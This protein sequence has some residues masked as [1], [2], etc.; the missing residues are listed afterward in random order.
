M[1]F[2]PALAVFDLDGTLADTRHDIARALLHVIEQQG[3][4]TPSLATA[5][6][7]IGW[8]APALVRKA[9]GPEHEHRA[10]AILPLFR[11]RYREHLV[12]ETTVYPGIE[13]LLADLRSGGTRLA[14]ATNKPSELTVALL[15]RLE[16]A[17]L[18]D[19]AVAPE[20]VARPKPAPDML[21]LLLQRTGVTADDAVM[22]GDM[23]T[24]VDS[25]HAA[26]MAAVLCRFSGFHRDADL[27]ERAEHVADTVH[28]LHTL[29]VDG[30]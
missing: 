9:L 16:L 4:P 3:L 11:R 27:G 17:P 10:N 13:R 29:L 2:P 30:A 7:S 18:F 15:E 8:G 19:H 5:I 26:G 1:P 12:V 23:E 14:V 25:A 22:V 28:E 24:D 20:D 21:E 6:A